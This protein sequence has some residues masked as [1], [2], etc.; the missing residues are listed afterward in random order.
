MTST[1]LLRALACLLLPILLQACAAPAE[2]AGPAPGDVTGSW[3]L[4][5]LGEAPVQPPDGGEQAGFTLDEDGA[6]AGFGGVNRISSRLDL[7]A[8]SAGRFELGPVVST[9]MA[10]PPAL[11]EQESAFL[12]ALAQASGCVLEGESLALTHAGDVLARLSRRP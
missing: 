9:R 11:M 8:L 3:I 7:A 10:G 2:A 6:L 1:A 4:T 12:A 5:E